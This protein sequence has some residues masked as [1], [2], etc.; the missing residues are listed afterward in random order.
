MLN[1][2]LDSNTQFPIHDD[3]HTA[4][5]HYNGI[6]PSLS[7]GI[8]ELRNLPNRPQS[9]KY[10]EEM[11]L[12]QYDEKYSHK[13]IVGLLCIFTPLEFI[14]ALG[15][16]PVR[17]CSGVYESVSE[18]GDMLPRDCCPMIKSTVGLLKE[19]ALPYMDNISTVI[20]PTACD[21]KMKLGEI[22]EEYYPVKILNLP[23]Q[24]EEEHFK[25]LWFTELKEVIKY[26]EKISG[27]RLNKKRL[28]ESIMF[29]KKAQVIFRKIHDLRKNRLI[30]GSDILLIASTF[31]FADINSWIKNSEEFLKEVETKKI[32]KKYPKVLLTGSPV[33]FPNIKLPYLI[34]SSGGIVVADEFCTTRILYDPVVIDEYSKKD[35]FEAVAEKY[36]LPSTC[37]CFTPNEERGR[38]ILQLCEDFSVDGVVYHVFKGCFIYDMELYRIEKKLKERGIPIIR[39]ETDYSSE[40]I[41]QIRT[42]VEAFLEMIS[43]NI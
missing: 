21:W 15:L 41:E 19:K 37:P 4:N 28:K 25:Q 22:L 38:K 29:L 14:Y 11:A 9:I 5:T 10:F 17:L 42:R 1:N 23:H 43:V 6:M 31:F 3:F 16:V 32:D 33:V 34:E 2:N 13:K 36:L 20:V 27:V 39:I 30:Y 35:L 8:E 7:R 40:D 24:K 18:A 26:L 12:K